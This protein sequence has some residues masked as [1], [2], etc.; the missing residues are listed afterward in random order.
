M[1][2]DNECPIEQRP[3]QRKSF[4]NSR[5]MRRVH[6][7]VGQFAIDIE[8][9]NMDIA[10]GSIIPRLGICPKNMILEMQRDNLCKK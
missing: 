9:S 10:F 8:R 1:I 3:V 2:K 7:S 4:S 6:L 5:S